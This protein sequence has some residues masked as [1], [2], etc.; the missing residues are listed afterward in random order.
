M[1]LASFSSKGQIVVPQDIREEF[2]I[3]QGTKASVFA[4][5]DEIVIKPIAKN[6]GTRLFGILKNSGMLAELE[7]EHRW[8]IERER[9]WESKRKSKKK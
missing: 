4:R 9:K 7:A 8:E 5:G 2:G 1:T 6:L 3:K